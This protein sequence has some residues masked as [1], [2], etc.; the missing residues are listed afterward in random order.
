[1]STRNNTPQG[2]AASDDGRDVQTCI[3]SMVDHL[4]PHAVSLDALWEAMPGA[5]LAAFGR[6]VDKADSYDLA[7]CHAALGAFDI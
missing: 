5:F 6:E 1:M 2:T 3:A 4:R 7:L